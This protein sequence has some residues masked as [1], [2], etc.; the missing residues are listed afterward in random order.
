MDATGQRSLDRGVHRN[1][2]RSSG[3][4]GIVDLER[5]SGLGDGRGSFTGCDSNR[6][7]HYG[8]PPADG[9]GA[10]RSRSSPGQWTG[11]DRRPGHFE[12][13]D[14]SD[15]RDGLTAHMIEAEIHAGT[16]PQT[17]SLTA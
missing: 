16:E 5:T 9:I 3:S 10:S 15:D 11:G 12:R 1:N 4:H 14:L 2:R 8:Q 7:H 13:G 17:H 6:G